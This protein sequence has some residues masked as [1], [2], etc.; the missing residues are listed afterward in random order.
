MNILFI[1]PR[2]SAFS[3]GDGLYAW[4]L[5][6]ELSRQGARI[7]VLSVSGGYFEYTSLG[8]GG[9]P[10]QA[11]TLE[12]A[13]Q[14]MWS[15]N[16]YCTAAARAVRT[17]MGKARPD[18]IHVHGLHQYFTLSVVAALKFSGVPCVLTVHDYKLL[19]G[20]AGFFSDRTNRPCFRCL[21]GRSLPAVTE[22]CKKGSV[23][24]S[25]AAAAQM[26]LWRATGWLHAIQI[27]HCGSHYVRGLLSQNASIRDRLRTIRMPMLQAQD[28]EA[29]DPATGLNVVYIG[30]MV[31]H[32]GVLIFAEAVRGMTGVQIDLFG[33]GPQHTA[34]ERLLGS[35][36]GVQFRGWVDHAAMDRYL[37]ADSTIVVVP[38]L[39]PETFCYVVV[40][41]MLR[42]CCV[43]T[44]AVGA[45]PELVRDKYNGILVAEAAA[46]PIR[47][48]IQHLLENKDLR[49]QLSAR[50][51]AVGTELDTLRRHGTKMSALYK[52]LK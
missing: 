22:R 46:K 45:I 52:T 7:S 34:A 11:D 25:S 50:A 35:T 3:G 48:A 37:R 32:K 12:R 8:P 36:P 42:G 40:E 26:L 20:N 33:D 51:R 27:F 44:S 5:A 13:G 14:N 39:A 49:L 29:V 2:F 16:Y 47:L 41:A 31:P 18:I 23:V 38:Y 4:H 28:V 15:L 24:Q 19:C 43:V 21:Q 10:V 6:H 9:L 1:T 30:R 17:S